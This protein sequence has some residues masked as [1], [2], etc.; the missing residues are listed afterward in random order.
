M[1]WVWDTKKQA[2]FKALKDEL[3]KESVLAYLDPCVQIGIS[4]DTSN[5]GIGVVLFHRYP[6]GSKR[7]IANVSMTL[8]PTQ[9][10]YSQIHK[11]ALAVF[12]GLKKFHQFLFG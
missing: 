2:A 9:H 4:C 12:F 11:E 6:D 1:Q 8:N 5:V 10:R 3:D 7:P